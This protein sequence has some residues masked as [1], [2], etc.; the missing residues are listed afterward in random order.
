MT[1]IELEL[2]KLLDG[3]L[4]GYDSYSS[5]LLSFEIKPLSA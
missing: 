3:S 5:N 1:K 4:N 2:I